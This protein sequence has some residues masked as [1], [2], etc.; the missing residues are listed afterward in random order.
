MMQV[1]KMSV[2][3]NSW[4]LH[5]RK[6]DEI[7]VQK[8]AVSHRF[9]RSLCCKDIQKNVCHQKSGTDVQKM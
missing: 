1:D 8:V 6:L 7:D 9:F 2:T 3:N 5:F 4:E